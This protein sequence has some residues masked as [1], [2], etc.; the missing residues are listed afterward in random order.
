MKATKRI[1]RKEREIEEKEKENT[2]I[3][4][5]LGLMGYKSLQVIYY[6]IL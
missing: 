5:C 1:S 2:N 3:L 6:E 4:V